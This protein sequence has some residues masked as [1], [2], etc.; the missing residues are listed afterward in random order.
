MASASRP[1]EDPGADRPYRE[2]AADHRQVIDC[3]YGG[4]RIVDCWRKRLAA[5][6]DLLP[7]AEPDVLFDGAFKPNPDVGVHRCLKRLG[8]GLWIVLRTRPNPADRSS[9]NHVLT[10]P[11]AEADGDIGIADQGEQ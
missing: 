6:V 3:L 9:G 11:I 10:D 5:N 8:S 1:G 4:I 2:L 7:N